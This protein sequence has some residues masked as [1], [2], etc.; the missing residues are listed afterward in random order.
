MA[1]VA[2]SR[3]AARLAAEGAAAGQI[4]FIRDPAHARRITEQNGLD[5]LALAEAAARMATK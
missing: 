1:E 5:A 2:V 3:N 4:A